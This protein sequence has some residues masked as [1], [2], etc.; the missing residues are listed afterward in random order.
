[1]TYKCFFFLRSVSANDKTEKY[2]AQILP[3]STQ[4][5]AVSSPNNQ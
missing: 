2:S 3:N 1:M 4:T 5:T